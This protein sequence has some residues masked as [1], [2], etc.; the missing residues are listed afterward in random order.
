M[1]KEINISNETRQR[2]ASELTSVSK[3]AKE[4]DHMKLD[5]YFE[6]PMMSWRGAE[7]GKTE[8]APSKSASVGMI[9]RAMGFDYEDTDELKKIADRFEI[10]DI[11]TFENYDFYKAPQKLPITT[12]E[13]M[14]DDHDYSVAPEAP[15]RNFEQQLSGRNSSALR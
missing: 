12:F 5:L 15:V 3:N 9:G 4:S 11:F 8:N 14:V 2:L 7:I 1:K 6:G 10:D 13:R